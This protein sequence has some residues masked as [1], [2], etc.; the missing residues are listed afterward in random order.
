MERAGEADVCGVQ[1]EGEGG[2]MLITKIKPIRS[3]ALR[4]SARGEQC[5]L[6]LPGICN[7]DPS[8]S[9]LAHLPFGGRGMGLKAG[10]TH[11][12]VACSSCHDALDGR[13]PAPIS[14]GELYECCLRAKA[15][16]E[17]LWLSAGLISVKG[18]Q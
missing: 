14:K 10:D 15:E 2:V 11:S 13:A 5:T 18:A 12:V 3:K 16:T 8:T 17:T 4:D 1:E 9:V 6:R 7:G